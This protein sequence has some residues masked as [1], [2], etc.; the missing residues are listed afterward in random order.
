MDIATSLRS[1]RITPESAVADSLRRVAQTEQTIRAWT[2]LDPTGAAHRATELQAS[3][4]TRGP[5]WGVPVAIKDLIDV[6]GL[7]TGCG[8][9]LKGLIEADKDA[10]CVA[11]LKEAGAIVIG[12]TVTTEFGYFRPGPTRNPV[13]PEHT[14]GGSSSGSAAAVASGAVALAL[15]TQTA[16]SLTRPASFC[17]VTGFVAAHKQFSLSGVTGLSHSLDTLG[18]LTRTVGDMSYAWHALRGLESPIDS[19]DPKP[20]RLLL[21]RGSDLGEISF[22]MTRA[23]EAVERNLRSDSH[24]SVAEWTNH[25]LIKQLTEDHAT[26]MAVEAAQEREEELSQPEAI[27]KPLLELLLTGRATSHRAYK[28]ALDRIAGA[29]A[30][31]LALMDGFDAILGP[32]ALGAAPVGIHATGSPVLSRPWQALGLP[33]LTIPGMRDHDGMPL[34]LQL[35]GMPGQE[36]RLFGIGQ[37][38]ENA[39]PHSSPQ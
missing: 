2:T 15:G 31:V 7:A 10:D 27:S 36:P 20:L 22:D 19:A 34:G 14:P 23:L 12:K 33:V 4:V 26:V 32:A 18:L 9:A 39:L 21:W 38:L 28:E 35:I 25:A 13:N 8:S 30:R 24:V 3:Q 11:L 37:H 17:G 16:G 1:G 5:L 6:E 29:R